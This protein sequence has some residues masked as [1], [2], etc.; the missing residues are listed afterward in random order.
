MRHSAHGVVNNLLMVFVTAISTQDIKLANDLL[1]PAREAQE[2]VVFFTSY[3][4]VERTSAAQSCSCKKRRHSPENKD[5]S[6]KS[7]KV[8]LE[9]IVSL[10]TQKNTLYVNTCYS[11][12]GVHT[13][14][15]D[16]T[17]AKNV[18]SRNATQTQTMPASFFCFHSTR[19]QSQHLHINARE[20]LSKSNY[21]H[22]LLLWLHVCKEEF[23]IRLGPNGR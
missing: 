2:G 22:V 20:A 16:T 19:T 17:Q 3:C 10:I 9:P 6:R 13:C 11:R 8:Q 5:I 7:K 12:A 18:W 1:G 14:P 4:L 15:W 21:Q 23:P